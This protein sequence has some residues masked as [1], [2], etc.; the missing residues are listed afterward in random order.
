MSAVIASTTAATDAEIKRF[1]VET[2]NEW[3]ESDWDDVMIEVGDSFR[4]VGMMTDYRQEIRCL[5]ELIDAGE[6]REKW[7][8]DWATL[9]AIPKKRNANKGQRLLFT[10]RNGYAS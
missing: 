7:R 1:L 10:K 4:K 8:G 6:V 5:Q 3:G 9:A 2:L